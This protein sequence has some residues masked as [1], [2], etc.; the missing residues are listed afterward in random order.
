MFSIVIGIIFTVNNNGKLKFLAI[1]KFSQNH[2][3]LFFGVSHGG[4]NNNSTARQ[5][6]SFYFKLI[7]NATIRDGGLGNCI[8]QDQIGILN[9]S[10]VKIKEPKDFIN[11]TCILR[12][13]DVE[14]DTEQL[15]LHDH[16]YIA[17]SNSL[18]S[19]SKKAIIYKARFVAHQLKTKI[20]CDICVNA[21][22]GEKFF[23]KIF[24]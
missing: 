10:S 13:I 8:H 21:H 4:Y 5:F 12:N 14:L 1:Y 17:N 15:N 16:D 23:L 20:K 9:T 11:E 18:L 24:N 3:K 2:L 19:F 22:F 7:I 6:R